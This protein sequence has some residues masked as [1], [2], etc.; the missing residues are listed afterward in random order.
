MSKFKVLDYYLLTV[1]GIILFI[2]IIF[3]SGYLSA[4]YTRTVGKTQRSAERSAF[5]GSRSYIV[6]NI[7]QLARYKLQWEQ[8]D[9]EGKIGIETTIRSQMAEFPAHEAP[10]ELRLFL[11]QIRGY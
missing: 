3:G 6:G 8:A 10:P 2:G 1:L 5:E 9:A 11:I 4:F 7:Q